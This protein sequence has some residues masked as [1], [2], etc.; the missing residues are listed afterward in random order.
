MEE[1]E[2]RDKPHQMY[3]CDETGFNMEQSRGKVLAPLGASHVYQQAQGTRDHLS[4][5]ACFNAAGEDVPAFIIYNDHFP[6][7]P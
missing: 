6:G 5:L 3:S 2:L 4:V 7:G 1:L